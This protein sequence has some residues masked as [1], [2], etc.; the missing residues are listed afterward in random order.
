MF[1]TLLTMTLIMLLRQNAIRKDPERW[2]A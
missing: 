2:P 1:V